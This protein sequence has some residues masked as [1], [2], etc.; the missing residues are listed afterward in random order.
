MCAFLPAL[1]HVGL[2]VLLRDPNARTTLLV[3]VGWS[4]CSLASCLHT[5]G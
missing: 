4:R 2:D 1:Q 3:P 5:F